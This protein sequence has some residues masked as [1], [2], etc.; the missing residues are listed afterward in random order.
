MDELFGMTVTRFERKVIICTQADV[1]TE[2]VLME[3]LFAYLCETGLVGDP[4]YLAGETGMMQESTWLIQCAWCLQEQGLPLGPGSHGIC[5]FH[6]DQ[7]MQDRRF[8]QTGW[9]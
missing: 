3:S 4:E 2:G 6:R 7:L 5:L 1:N 8:K 9:T